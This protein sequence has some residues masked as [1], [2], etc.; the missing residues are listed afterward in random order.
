MPVKY[1]V[2][3]AGYTGRWETFTCTAA[4]PREAAARIKA[5]ITWTHHHRIISIKETR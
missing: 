1:A 5:R 2:T 4:S 3:V